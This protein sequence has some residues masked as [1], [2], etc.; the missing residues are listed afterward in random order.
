MIY[1]TISQSP[2][3]TA[4]Q[5]A[6]K[7]SGAE[8]PHFLSSNQDIVAGSQ[9]EK[10]GVCNLNFRKSNTDSAASGQNQRLSFPMALEH[11]GFPCPDHCAIRN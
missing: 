3:E 11:S 10:C 4:V 6:Q 5:D 9:E 1:V 7:K 2:P 8:A